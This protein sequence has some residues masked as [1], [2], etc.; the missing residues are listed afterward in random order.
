[1]AKITNFTNFSGTIN[2]LVYY[3]ANGKQFVRMDKKKETF[4][5]LQELPKETLPSI[6]AFNI[7]SAIKSMNHLI[8]ALKKNS[9]L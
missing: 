2:G 1:M 3:M 9:R 5:K 6:E 8:T 4:T 7:T